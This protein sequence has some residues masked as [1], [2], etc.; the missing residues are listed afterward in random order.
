MTIELDDIAAQLFLS[1][2]LTQTLSEAFEHCIFNNKNVD[3]LDP[4][5]KVL[6]EQQTKTANLFDDYVLQV[7]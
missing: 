1:C 7:Y 2:S 4:L 6:H 5:C 3:H